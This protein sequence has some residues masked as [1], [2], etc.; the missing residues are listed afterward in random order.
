MSFTNRFGWSISRESLFEDCRRK[1]Y[2][3]YY[4]SWEGWKKTAS[5]LRQEAFKLKRLV[6]LPL[7]RGQLVHYVTAKVLES[8]RRKGKIPPAKDV[9]SYTAERFQ[10]QLDF[11]RRKL[12]LS[13]PKK[14]GDRLNIDWLALFEHEYGREL[15]KISIE[16][17]LDESVQGVECLLRS[18]IIDIISKT[19]PAHWIIEN[20]DLAEFAQVFDFE[21]ARVFAKTDFIYTGNDGSF[22]IIDWK[23]FRRKEGDTEDEKTGK[24]GTQLGVYGYYAAN[25]LGKPIEKVRLYEVNLLGPGNHIEQIINRENIDTFC[26]HIRGGISRLSSLLVDRDIDKNLP[27]PHR[28]FPKNV[29]DS[30]R[31]CNFFRICLD[32]KSSLRLE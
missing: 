27:L 3:H 31:F 1:Y 17:T 23:T 25:V 11:S 15:S 13:Q 7:W 4:L 10:Q 28:H 29:S 21:G 12:Y 19:D 2:F 30:C 26:A 20:I 8:M 6:S 14:R 22:N 16:R 32:E 24:A 18:P 5:P 9:A